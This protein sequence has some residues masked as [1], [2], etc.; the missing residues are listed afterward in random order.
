GLH[1]DAVDF[2]D[3]SNDVILHTRDV[4]LNVLTDSSA[5]GWTEFSPS[6]DTRIVYVSSSTG[7]DANNG[8]SHTKPK[9]T[10]AAGKALLRDG[11]PDWLLL[12]RGDAWGESLDTDQEFGLEGRSLTERMLVSA[13]GAGERPLLRTGIGNGVDSYTK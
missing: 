10:I 1:L 8:L 6:V 2:V 3:A 12:K 4:S 7:D 11:F 5:A 13:Y 9:R